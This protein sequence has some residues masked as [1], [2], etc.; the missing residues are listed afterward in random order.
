MTENGL[1]GLVTTSR[2]QVGNWSPYPA[3]EPVDLPWLDEAPA[4][5]SLPRLRFVTRVNPPKSDL[6]PS[7]DDKE[8]VSFVPMEAVGEGGGLELERKRPLYS[9][10]DQYTYF[11]DGDVLIAKITPCFENGKGALAGDLTSGVGFGTTELHVL[12]PGS[13]VERRFLFY[14]T[15]SHHFRRIGEH[16]MY[17]A[18]GQKRIS[19]TFVAQFRHPIP[20]LED[21][22]VIA[23]FLERETSRIEKLIDRKERLA[24]LLKEKRTA[25]IERAVAG[26]GLSTCDGRMSENEYTIPSHWSTRKIRGLITRVRRPVQVQPDR[27]YREIGIRSW[28]NGIF[29]KDELVGEDL[30]SKKVHYIRPGDF[31]INIVFAWE[32]A[33]AVASEAEGGMIASHRF[34]TF[35]H[36]SAAVDLDYLLLF[37]QSERG[38]ALLSLNSPGAAGRNRTIRLGSFVNEEIPLP[39]LAEQ[40]S[41]VRRVREEESHLD[42]LCSTVETGMRYLAEYRTAL[43]SAAVTGQIDVRE[44]A[45]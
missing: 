1:V 28:G 34:P 13:R 39:P 15:Q 42:R 35:R 10:R 26:T 8:P 24:K 33:V 32:G 27:K 9:V 23:N 43:I 6:E 18:G 31:I 36:N 22:R 16:A 4:R 5:W 45:A 20:P 11:E 30:G 3:Y 7:L 29:H 25:M 19:T 41:I 21:Q 38:R 17:G 2:N 14:L 40:R 44:G 12:R 37:F